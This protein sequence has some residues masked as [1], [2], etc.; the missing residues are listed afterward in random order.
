MIEVVQVKRRIIVSGVLAV[1]GW[2]GIGLGM[3]DAGVISRVGGGGSVTL[4]IFQDTGSGFVNVTDTYLPT[5]KPAGP[6]QTVYV[7]VNGSA[8]LPT[9]VAPTATAPTP[10]NPNPFL[11]EVTTSAY[12]G[13]CTNFTS[14]DA[15]LA[16]GADFVFNTLAE[17]ATPG[18]GTGYSLISRDCG[19]MAVVQVGTDKFIIPKDNPNGI[20]DAL[21][22]FGV[23]LT[24]EG[25]PDN[26]GLSTFDELRGFI[27][28]GQHI[29][30]NPTVKNL[31]VFL[32]RPQ[33]GATSLLANGAPVKY[34]ISGSGTLIDNLNNLIPVPASIP[35]GIA[36]TQIHFLGSS[37]DP[38]IL[39][40]TQTDEWVDHFFSFSIIS[41][42]E[43]WK[44][45][46]EANTPGCFPA[47][48]VPTG[49]PPANDR[50]INKNRVY[51]SIVKGVR[52]TECLDTSSTTP[53]GTGRVGSATS[54]RDEAIVYTK[55]IVNFINSIGKSNALLHYSTA[56]AAGVWQPLTPAI[57]RDFISSKCMQFIVAMEVAHTVA[58]NQELTTS[59]HPHYTAGTGNN[60]DQSIRAVLSG[61]PSGIKFYIP[62]LFK[63]TDQGL[64][65]IFP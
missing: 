55:R 19:G 63:D 41:G 49:T 18:G 57:S 4:S 9:L 26:D 1:W 17:A 6:L 34:P 36:N 47:I 45:C 44:Y 42:I 33:C 52:L 53:L 29:R 35:A 8:T 20:P 40:T 31:S 28:G 39:V 43:T 56:N 61:S 21:E 32:V 16:T 11:S 65:Q 25:D 64:L 7:V 12:P 22:V 58:L 24:P 2:L 48:T 54:G 62:S 3:A 37:L 59:I 50:V 51:G 38:S 46:N 5:W 10:G 15:A 30:T 23:P 27:V 13:N 60:L 14:T